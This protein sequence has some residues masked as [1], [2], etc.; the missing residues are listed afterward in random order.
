MRKDLIKMDKKIL[1][2]L[3]IRVKEFYLNEKAIDN[4]Q[5]IKQSEIK[6][7]NTEII[8]RFKN[9]NLHLDDKYFDNIL[10]IN[11]QR[12]YNA[13]EQTEHRDKGKNILMYG[14][15]QSGKTNNTLLM[16]EILCEFDYDIIFLLGGTK[17]DLLHQN[18]NRFSDYK[19]AFRNSRS[20]L[21]KDIKDENGMRDIKVLLNKMYYEKGKNEHL[22]LFIPVL[23]NA[24]WLK[25]AIELL[26]QLPYIDKMKIAILDDESDEASTDI[27]NQN[28]NDDNEKVISAQIDELLSNAK[29]YRYIAIT[30]TPNYNLLKTNLDSKRYINFIVPLENQDTYYGFKKFH[31][32]SDDH[33]ETIPDGWSAEKVVAHF[34]DE[35]FNIAKKIMEDSNLWNERFTILINN[36]SKKNSHSNDRKLVDKWFESTNR[37]GNAA[38]KELLNEFKTRVLNSDNKDAPTVNAKFNII[39]GGYA[40]SRGITFDNLISEL[41]LNYSESSTSSTMTQ[42]CRWFGYRDKTFKYTKIFLTE[43]LNQL[44]KNLGEIEDK[45]FLVLADGAAYDEN[46]KRYYKRLYEER[47]VDL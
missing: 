28:N 25:N 1:K 43:K 34:L 39:I 37:S 40:L 3:N 42:R 4:V 16:A 14:R 24:T 8:S 38:D 6:I 7:S 22:K 45:F 10:Q 30:A 26:K 2:N 35:T 20:L 32:E 5:G 12:I 36:D 31:M 29:S 9:L 17:V 33:I 44:Y 47:K 21:F 41:I 13:V 46:I 27:G 15:V 18:A 23:K 19:E 11:Y